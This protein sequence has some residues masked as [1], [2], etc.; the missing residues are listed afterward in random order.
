MLY[1]FLCNNTSNIWEINSTYS[2]QLTVLSTVNVTY[3]KLK[4]SY[5]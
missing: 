2:R 3:S 1:A 4:L 5:E